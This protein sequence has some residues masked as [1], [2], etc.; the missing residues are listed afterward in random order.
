MAS[1]KIGKEIRKGI[2]STHKPTNGI[3]RTGA[4]MAVPF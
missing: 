2:K 1:R 3:E 4:M